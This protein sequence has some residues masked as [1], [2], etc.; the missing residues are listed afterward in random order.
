MRTD[1]SYQMGIGHQFD[2]RFD[3]GLYSQ[4]QAC[5]LEKLLKKFSTSG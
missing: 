1:H 4:L 5:D 2:E 3:I